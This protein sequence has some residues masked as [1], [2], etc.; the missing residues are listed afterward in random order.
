I[1]SISIAHVSL[2]QSDPTE[3]KPIKKPMRVQA[4]ES[5]EIVDQKTTVPATLS[6]I[7]QTQILRKDMNFQGLIVTDAM[8]MS[9]LT[10]YVTQEEAGVRAFL[11]GADILE[12]PADTE[13]MRKGMIDAVKSGR[14]TE[15]RLNE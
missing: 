6:P 14:I 1:G 15:E 2:P 5:A 8:G 12:K 13:A 9:G 11:A 4:E 7:V 10:L 3:V